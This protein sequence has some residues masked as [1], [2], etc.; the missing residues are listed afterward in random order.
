MTEWQ[1]Q[2]VKWA[3]DRL[4][5]ILY[6]VFK[7]KHTK[8]K[9]YLL[10]PTYSWPYSRFSLFGFL[11][12]D[13]LVA[14]I[15]NDIEEASIKLEHPEHLKL[16]EDNFFTSTPNFSSVTTSSVSQTIMNGHWLLALELPGDLFDMFC[17]LTSLFKYVASFSDQP[18]SL[19]YNG[20]FH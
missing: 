2:W 5:L 16:K 14:A 19:A 7:L 18:V 4:C 9:L 17:V 8:V 6:L 15:Y 13:A 12:K 3:W 10:S 11:S 1:L 20:H